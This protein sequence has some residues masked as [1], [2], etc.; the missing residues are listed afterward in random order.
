MTVEKLAEM[1][2]LN[3]VVLLVGRWVVL[4]AVVKAGCLVAR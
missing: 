4:K 1:W 2:D 3:W